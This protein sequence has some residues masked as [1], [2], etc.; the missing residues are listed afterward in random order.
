MIFKTSA[1]FLELLFFH[2]KCVCDKVTVEEKVLF[3][4]EGK[5]TFY[6][7][8]QNLFSVCHVKMG[9]TRIY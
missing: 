4:S 6:L 7:R 8:K 9:R 3:I 2:A 5:P 1:L